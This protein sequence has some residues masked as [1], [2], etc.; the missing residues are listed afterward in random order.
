MPSPLKLHEDVPP[1]RGI[2]SIFAVNRPAQL[3]DREE[4]STATTTPALR[5]HV[6]TA[7][8]LSLDELLAAVA[9]MAANLDETPVGRPV[10]AFHSS[11]KPLVTLVSFAWR[12]VHHSGYHADGLAVGLALLGRYVKATDAAPTPLTVHRL[13]ATC[14]VVGMKATSDKFVKNVY[15]A[16]IV[17]VPLVELNWLELSLMKTLNFTVLPTAQEILSIPPRLLGLTGRGP[18]A[19][20]RA[21]AEPAVATVAFIGPPAKPRRRFDTQSH[22]SQTQST[23]TADA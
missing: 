4:P 16:P 23:L 2:D 17:G 9:T 12:I 20:L 10:T 1:L 14:I 5:A 13:L 8:M 18:E 11:V 21:L 19:L 3:R 22:P 7:P 15:M 6:A